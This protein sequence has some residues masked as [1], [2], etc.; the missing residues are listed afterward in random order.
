MGSNVVFTISVTNGGP[1]AASGVQVKD[2]LPSGYSYVS[3]NGA[4]AYNSGTGIWTVGALTNG[5][6]KS[7]QITATV[8]ASGSYANYAQ[9][10]ASGQTDPDSTPN[11]NSTNQ[12]DDDT[13][14]RK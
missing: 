7:L 6:T 12:D 3:D 13:V 2:Q 1:S 8:L 5:Q 14:T 9:V 10:T 11:D 4:G